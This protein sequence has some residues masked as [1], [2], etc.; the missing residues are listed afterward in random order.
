MSSLTCVKNEY[1]SSG[2]KKKA[3]EIAIKIAL[4]AILILVLFFFFLF[5]STV[6]IRQSLLLFKNP[7]DQ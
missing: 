1:G 5:I 2:K 3:R 6:K 7:L 4:V